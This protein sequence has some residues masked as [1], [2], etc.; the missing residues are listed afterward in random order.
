ML[1]FLKW[2]CLSYIWIYGTLMGDELFKF[3]FYF[4]FSVKK[5]SSIWSFNSFP[6]RSIIPNSWEFRAPSYDGEGAWSYA[7]AHVKE[8]RVRSSLLYFDFAVT[9][10]SNCVLKTLN[11]LV[12]VGMQRSILE[13]ECWIGLKVQHQEKV[14]ELFLNC[15]GFRLHFNF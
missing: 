14:S 7:T 8:S 13:R 11:C 12:A 2:R 10:H 3:S 6:G 1:L 4:Y 9:Y 15:L 5:R